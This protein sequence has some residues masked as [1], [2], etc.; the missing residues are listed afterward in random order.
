MSDSK[1]IPG[2][3]QD[4]ERLDEYAERLRELHYAKRFHE[5]Q[6]AVIRAI[7][8]DGY[9]RVFI[10]KGRKGGGTQTVLYPAARMAMTGPAKGIYIIGPTQ[11]AQAEIIWANRRMHNF[12]PQSWNPEFRESEYRVRFPNHS[13]IKIE[14]AN[15]PEAARGWEGDLFIWDEL[16]D[17]N[18]KSLENC[19]PNVAARDGTWIVLGSPPR[20]RDNHYYK[21]EQEIR[22]DPDWFFIHWS[23]WDNP[24]L[25]GGHAW[26]AKEKAKF[27]ARGDADVWD[28]EWEAKY[29]FTGKHKVLPMLDLDKHER[30]HEVVTAKLDQDKSKLKWVCIVDPGYAT[31]F[32]VLFLAY[33]PYTSQVFLLDEIY[34]TDRSQNG[35]PTIWPKIKAMQKGLYEGEWETLY[36]SAALGFATEVYDYERRRGGRVTLIPT[37]KSKDDEDSYFRIINSSLSAEERVTI[38]TRCKSLLWEADKYETNEFGKYPDADNHMLDNWRYGYKHLGYTMDRATPKIIPVNLEPRGFSIEEDMR[39]M[40]GNQ[41]MVGY[42]DFNPDSLIKD[43]LIH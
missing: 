2:T 41:D 23:C 43:F 10:R 37:N 18:P 12:I 13:F 38:S 19:Y 34:S 7:F 15:D 9:K 22:K 36:D 25:P 32:A 20:D 16:K 11:K 35:T 24:F 14:G 8:K 27:Y 30:P 4:L 33:N 40:R 6:M 21:L 31:C 29:V 1:I 26:L 39:R 3:Q 28:S 17:H 5:K 42:G